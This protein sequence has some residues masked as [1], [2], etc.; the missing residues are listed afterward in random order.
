[1]ERDRDPKSKSVETEQSTVGE[2]ER[3]LSNWQRLAQT[4]QSGGDPSQLLASYG[5]DSQALAGDRGLASLE[6]R[7]A[8]SGDVERDAQ[9]VR[10]V[11][12]LVVGPVALA[13]AG[14]VA[15]VAVAVDAAA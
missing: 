5:I 15:G 9:G 13:V 2:G 8:F 11:A 12:S 10:R 3:S 4:R 1:M 7:L 14:A 6:K